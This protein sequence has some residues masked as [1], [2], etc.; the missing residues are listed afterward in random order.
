M[1]Y[2]GKNV[3]VVS[4]KSMAVFDNFIFKLFKSR[5]KSSLENPKNLS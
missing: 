2:V 5:K 1:K 3:D 4:C